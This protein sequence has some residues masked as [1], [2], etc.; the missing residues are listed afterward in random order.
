MREMKR[1]VS[2]VRHGVAVRLL[3]KCR[4]RWRVGH[5]IHSSSTA[6]VWVD[7]HFIK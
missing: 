1:N 4:V 5:Y 7:K 2:V 6:A 3:K